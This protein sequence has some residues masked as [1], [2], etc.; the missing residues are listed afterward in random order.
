[1]TEDSRPIL[2]LWQPTNWEDFHSYI[3]Y[4]G[5]NNMCKECSGVDKGWC[6]NHKQSPIHLE[7]SITARRECQDRHRMNY[8]EGNC[9]YA[10]FHF[11]ILPHVLRAYQPRHCGVTPNIDFSMGFPRPW[12]LE[13]TDI[14]VP[15]QHVMNGKRYDAEVVLSHTY[16]V[17]K[18][19]RL[20]SSC[21]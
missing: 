8:V 10:G 21:S 15:S 5:T 12:L 13:F 16:S 3:P 6:R 19:D 14:S 9:R 2:F 20:V 7:T 4:E 11:E 17:R 18:A 1:M